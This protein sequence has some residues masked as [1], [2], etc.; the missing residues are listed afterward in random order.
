[1]SAEQSWKTFNHVV[2][3]SVSNLANSHNKMHHLWFRGVEKKKK[4]PFYIFQPDAVSTTTKYC[5]NICVSLGFHTRS[6]QRSQ[7]LIISKMY[8]DTSEK[9]GC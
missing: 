5:Q 4:K 8:S 3:H 7:M 1:M 9:E 6:D 2:L